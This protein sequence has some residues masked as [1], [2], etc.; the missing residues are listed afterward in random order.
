[1]ALLNEIASNMEFYERRAVMFLHGKGISFPMWIESIGNETMYCDELA[2]LGLCVVYSRHCLVIIRDKFWS[3]LETINPIGMMDLL[4]RCNIKLLFL[5]QLRFGVLNWNP[6]PPKA[7]PRELVPKFSIVEEYTIDEPPPVETR[8]TAASSI[9]NMQKM[10][11]TSNDTGFPVETTPAAHA[12][13]SANPDVQKTV[14][15]NLP[16]NIT[17]TAEQPRVTDNCKNIPDKET[18]K[19]EGVLAQA[20]PPH[21]SEN[22]GSCLANVGTYVPKNINVEVKPARGED[23]LVIDQ[24]LWKEKAVVKVKRLSDISV[25]IWCNNVSTYYEYQPTPDPL[26]E[27]RNVKLTLVKGYGG[28]KR[29]ITGENEVIDVKRERVAS[30]VE[31]DDIGSLQSQAEKLV[32]KAKDLATVPDNTAKRNKSNRRGRVKVQRSNKTFRVWKQLQMP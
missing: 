24:Y 5:G 21:M 13:V 30:P 14:D 17:L 15:R 29:S 25:D 32:N 22:S 12:V 31:T 16:V 19:T 27:P 10:P 1:M 23:D 8:D 18:I 4:K 28:T 11:V 7:K 3:T 9:V 20:E 26:S 2:L 6:R